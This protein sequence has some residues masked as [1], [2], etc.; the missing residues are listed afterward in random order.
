[1]AD[2]QIKTLLKKITSFKGQN[3]NVRS[4]ISLYKLR[5]PLDGKLEERINKY[6][7]RFAEIEQVFVQLEPLDPENEHHAV[8]LK[9]NLEADYNNNIAE[10]EKLV[11]IAKGEHSS[12]SGNSTSTDEGKKVMRKVKL[13]DAK[14]PKFNGEFEHWLSFKA[15]FESLIHIREDLTD[16]DKM[17]YL[18]SSLTGPAYEK[19]RMM[20]I[21]AENYARAWKLL[22]KTYSD[23]RILIS[24]HL[25]LLLAL[26]IQ[27]KETAVGLSQLVDSTRQ[28][29]EVLSTMGV[30]PGDHIIVAL[31]E[32][33]LHKNTAEAWDEKLVQGIYPSLRKLLK[34]LSQRAARMINR[35]SNIPTA[36]KVQESTPSENRKTFKRSHAQAFFTDSDK[37]CTLCDEKL[38][39]LY[40]CKTFRN[41]TVSRRLNTIEA[42]GFCGNCL[43]NNHK[44]VDCNS[45]NN[46]WICK[47]NHNTLL[48]VDAVASNSKDI[49]EQK[50]TD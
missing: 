1:M 50:N 21:T 18:R 17:S 35:N 38:H 15:E 13:P 20:S 11:A 24:R 27:D 4:F 33:K 48:H 9:D 16:T 44:T 7:E 37:K 14:P 5:D 36:S 10:Y 26:P 34:F 3:T 42:G 2:A 47:E 8:D 28:H 12:V 32:T 41:M 31:L 23:E 22:N 30:E 19:I 46:C 39:P 43:R 49:Q 40:R 29:L 45:K 25:K 6:N